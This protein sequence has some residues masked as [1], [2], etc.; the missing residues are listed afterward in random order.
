MRVACRGLSL[1]VAKYPPHH[2]QTLASHHCLGREPVPEVMDANILEPGRLADP[3]PRLLQ[4]RQMRALCGPGD[5]IGV[6]L[7]TLRPG[8][9]LQ[10]RPVE[11]DCLGTRLRIRQVNAVTP[12]MFPF[13]RLD[14]RQTRPRVQQ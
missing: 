12:D 3:P 13:Q 6:V 14:L 7:D 4:V 2:R 10:R 11:G 5:H 1:G 8:Q 9:N